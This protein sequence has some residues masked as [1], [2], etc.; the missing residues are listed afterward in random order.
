MQTLNL[1][2]KIGNQLRWYGIVFYLSY[3]KLSVSAVF[4]PL[5]NYFVI[6]IPERLINVTNT[7]NLH[8][9]H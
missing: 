7:R 8:R 1:Y 5:N 4:I 9:Y 3:R 2:K 6:I